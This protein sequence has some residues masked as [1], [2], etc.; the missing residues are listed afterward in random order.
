MN[1]SRPAFNMDERL[2]WIGFNL[3]KGTGAVCFQAMLDRLGDAKTAWAASPN[4]LAQAGLGAKARERFLK[5]RTSMDLKGYWDQICKHDLQVLIGQ[6]E[7][8]PPHLKQVAQPPPVPL[9]RGEITGEDHGLAC[10]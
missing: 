4:D 2:D 9:R 1:N 5:V 7:E 8:Y 10:R 6:D 3:A